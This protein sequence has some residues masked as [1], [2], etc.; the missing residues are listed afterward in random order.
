MPLTAYGS[1][2]F[3]EQAQFFRRKLNLPTD[4]WT[5]IYTREH[6]WAFVVAGANRDAIV[7]DFRA[8]VDKAIEGGSTLEDFRRDFDRIVATHGWDYNGGRNWRSRVLYGTNLATSYAAGRWQQLQGA[9]YWQYEHQDWV[10]HPREQHIAWNGLVLEKDDPAWQVMFP[11][12]GW[13]C[14]CTVRG[15]WPRD[16]ARLGKAGP[17]QAPQFQYVE[18]TIGQRSINGPRT[19]RVPEGIDPGFEYAPGSARLRSAIPPE[20]PDPPLPGSTGGH[21][22]SNRRPPDPLPPPRTLPASVLL[23]PGQAPEAY[24]SQFLGAFGATLDAPAIVRDVIGERVVVGKELFQDARGEWKVLK[25]ERERYLPLLAQALAAPDEIWARVEWLHALGRAVVR[26][27]YLARYV[28]EGQEG[29]TP[30]LAVF[31]LGADGWS[32][33]TAFPAASDDYLEHARIGVRLYRR[34]P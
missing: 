5:D 23:P 33:V 24:V 13:G 2:P 9:P 31:E 15:L 20:R 1:L 22:L 10:Q 25:R 18:R 6:D 21:G 16:L 29:N 12:N 11:P 14:H 7:A 27:R 8:A 4:G 3:A 28:I 30:G 34:Q 26:R 19:V 17:D 32:G